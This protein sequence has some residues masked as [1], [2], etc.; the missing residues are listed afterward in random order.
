MGI[1]KDLKLGKNDFTNGATAFFVAYAV[2]EI[3]QGILL[4]KFT[5]S[6]VLGANIFLWG[7]A[8]CCTAAVKTGP[9]LIAMRAVLGSLESVIT[10]ALIMLTSAWYKKDE[11]AP[12]FGFWYR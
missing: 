9:Q 1:Q 3:P 8:T 2:A 7:V 11:S 6:K 10:P 12:R 4:Q 5:V